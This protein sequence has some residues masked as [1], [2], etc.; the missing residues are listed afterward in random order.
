[1]GNIELLINEI[2]S[3]VATKRIREEQFELLRQSVS[4]EAERI[5]K[6]FKEQFLSTDKE[7]A[8]RR[9][10][11]LH[12]T[13]LI[14]LLDEIVDKTATLEP[15]D[16]NSTEISFVYS[17][18]ESLLDFLKN[19]FPQYFSVG[20]KAP[21][22]YSESVLGEIEGSIKNLLVIL[23]ESGVDDKIKELIAATFQNQQKNVSYERLSYMQLL[24][25]EL[26]Q[27][28]W[29]DS[30]SERIRQAFVNTLVKSNFNEKA[31]V[32]YYSEHISGA[33]TACETLTDKVDQLGYFVKVMNQTH[34][35]P[36]VVYNPS[37]PGI[38]EQLLEWLAHE[39]DYVQLK[40]QLGVASKN[41]LVIKKDFKLIFDMSVANLA[42][43]FKLFIETGIIQNK[44]ASEV[45]RFLTKFVK[46]KKSETVSYESFRIKY[47]NTESGTKDAVKKILQSL[48]NSISKN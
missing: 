4:E 5:K 15:G 45:I 41:D 18:T 31:F 34:V 11:Q 42:F 39:L 16:L 35:M 3:L 14:S 43:L 17:S 24:Q 21:L 10:F 36:N 27:I 7:T 23:S 47:Y 46:T 9:F 12:T 28:E 8:R 19:Q 40:L 37:M 29:S 44:N 26:S 1:L 38:K 48:V 20:F 13:L 25:A 6:S 2:I 30:N 32:D 33:L 22:R